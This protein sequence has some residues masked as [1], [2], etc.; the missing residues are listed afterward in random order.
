MESD[1]REMN[2]KDCSSQSRSKDPIQNSQNIVQSFPVLAEYYESLKPP[3]K[4]RYLEKISVVE[5]NPG[6]LLDARLDSECL[7]PI[8][9][10]DLFS[11]LGL[12]VHQ[13]K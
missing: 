10:I 9:A 12:D 6:T 1:F 3:V 5:F 7:P 2:E 4:Q 8:E 11:Y 13:L